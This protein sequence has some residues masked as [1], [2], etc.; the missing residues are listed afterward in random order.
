LTDAIVQVG[1]HASALA[2]FAARRIE[3]HTL[4]ARLVPHQSAALKCMGAY[5]V[6]LIVRRLSK[7]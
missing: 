7:C 6:W 2:L 1:G 5:T 3:R 4:E